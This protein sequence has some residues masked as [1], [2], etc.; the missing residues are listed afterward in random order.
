MAQFNQA[1]PQRSG[2]ERFG[3]LFLGSPGQF[4]QFGLNTPQQ[5]QFLNQD[6]LSI[7]PQ[8]LQQSQQRTQGG[9]EPIA[10]ASINRFK[11]QTIPSLAER[12]T[13]MGG[14][15]NS[16][17]FQGAI[18]QAG[19]GLEENLDALESQYNLQQGGQQQNLLLSLLGLF[20]RPQFEN[21]YTPA[22]QGIFHGLSQGFGQGLGSFAAPS[23]GGGL[24]ALGS[25]ISSAASSAASGIGSLF[26]RS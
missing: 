8:L 25:G 16:S 6:I 26:N 10:K 11:T 15:Q 20:L 2:L 4:N 9:F 21:T 14:G 22:G 3:D 1:S 13:A 23:V 5:S 12:F 18:G 19:A 7:L 17:A 24:S